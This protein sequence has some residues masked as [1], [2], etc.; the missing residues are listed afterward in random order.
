M[1]LRGFFLCLF[2][3]KTRFLLESSS[4]FSLGFQRCSVMRLVTR[5]LFLEDQLWSG[6][7][8]P[9]PR[10]LVLKCTKKDY[11]GCAQKFRNGMEI[12]TFFTGWLFATKKSVCL[13]GWWWLWEQQVG[14]AGRRFVTQK[15]HMV[16]P[17]PIA[18]L[19]FSHLSLNAHKTFSH[20]IW[21]SQHREMF[22]ES[23]QD[24]K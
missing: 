10:G 12:N 2:C 22:Q 23:F 7:Q 14:K 19:V 21:L 24:L 13:G 18:V 15:S 8:S 9:R 5:V 4:M 1:L 16:F 6:Y 3:Y 11:L 20:S 17:V